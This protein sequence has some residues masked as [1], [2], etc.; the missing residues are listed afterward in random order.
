A[1]LDADRAAELL[2]I[3]LEQAFQ[4]LDGIAVEQLVST[5]YRRFRRLGR[6]RR[7][8]R[9]AEKVASVG[10]YLRGKIGRMV[11]HHAA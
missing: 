7:H 9:L 6:T 5:R 1:H 3:G 11:P 2:A 10:G 8:S 4:E